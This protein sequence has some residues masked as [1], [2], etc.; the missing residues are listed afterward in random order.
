MKIIY[1]IQ[2]IILILKNIIFLN[3]SIFIIYKIILYLYIKENVK[4][5]LIG[6]YNSIII[7]ILSI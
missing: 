7:F 3:H 2:K 5:Y 4:I 1:C 6:D